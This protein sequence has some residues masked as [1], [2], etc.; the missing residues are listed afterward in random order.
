MMH[1]RTRFLPLLTLAALG[2]WLGPVPADA[3]QLRG[4]QAA[5]PETKQAPRQLRIERTTKLQP[6][7]DAEVVLPKL[8]AFFLS[9]GS[10]T[11]RGQGTAKAG[12][13][14]SGFDFTIDLEK[15]TYTTRTLTP[16]EIREREPQQGA[17]GFNR[18]GPA[19]GSPQEKV[20]PGNWQGRVRVQTKDPAFIVLTETTAR[21]S[22]SVSAGG[23]VTWT[24]YSD[25]CWAANPSSLGTHWYNSSCSGGSAYYNSN[26]ACNAN[27]G[28]YYNY[29]FVDP[30]A[31]TFVTDSDWLCGRNDAI[32][33][34]NWSHSDSGE[35]AILIYG[36]VLTN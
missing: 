25:G 11:V 7:P 29:D 18:T 21:V 20:S 32:F 9:D 35:G 2:A 33:D 24:S 17:M 19:P 14:P 5:A 27:T 34:Y 30:N 31:G 12:A 28:S 22:W 8:E 10:V 36:S 13:P 3:A 15:G 1:R 4:D 6:L 26:R 23:T 16:E